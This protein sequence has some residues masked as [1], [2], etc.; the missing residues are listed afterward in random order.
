VESVL[1]ALHGT[2]SRS[3]FFHCRFT[4]RADIEGLGKLIRRFA[5]AGHMPYFSITDI[6]TNTVEAQKVT[7]DDR[8]L[9]RMITSRG[10]V[11]PFR[12]KEV[13]IRATNKDAKTNI[14]LC[15]TN[16]ILLPI[17][18]VPRCLHADTSDHPHPLGRPGLK[19]TSSIR[20]ASRSGS[21]RQRRFDWKP[22]NL[23]VPAENEDVIA[24]YSDVNHMLGSATSPASHS[25]AQ[26]LGASP[27]GA[28]D[29]TQPRAPTNHPSSTFEQL[30]PAA[31]HE[32][33]AIE[34][35][36]ELPGTDAIHELPVT[37]ARRTGPKF[38]MADEDWTDTGPRSSESIYMSLTCG[39]VL[40]V[41]EMPSDGHNGSVWRVVRPSDGREGWVPSHC[42]RPL[43]DVTPRRPQ[44]DASPVDGVFW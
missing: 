38:Y 40:Q 39:D 6:T 34:V 29:I 24:R 21:Q 41:L 14:S 17:S 2:N 25:E 26:E 42:L 30:R 13:T 22:P 19:P 28:R 20:W 3:G 7:I 9:N 31:V 36:Q 15:F 10:L 44:F 8:T 18:G 43:E 4:E 12:M 5:T 32:L 16:G 37:E 27:G 11:P 1:V 33:P 35:I 23:P